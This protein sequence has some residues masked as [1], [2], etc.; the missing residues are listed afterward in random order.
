MSTGCKHNYQIKIDGQEI[1]KIG[2]FSYLGSMIDV[3]WGAD[4]DEHVLAKPRQ[5]S[6]SPKPTWI[7]SFQTDLSQDHIKALQLKC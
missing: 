5:K 7:L 4:A 2:R 6:S 1:E 3:Q